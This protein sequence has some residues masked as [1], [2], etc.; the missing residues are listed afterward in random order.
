M[1]Y[2]KNEMI[3]KILLNLESHAYELMEEMDKDRGCLI[4]E[5]KDY[6]EDKLAC[7]FR[8]IENAKE[9]MKR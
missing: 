4:K 8:S 7:I 3:A 5:I 6:K 9:M 1:T 2:N